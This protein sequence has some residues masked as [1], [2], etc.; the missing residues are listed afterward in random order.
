VIG[1]SR[2][3]RSGP[4]ATLWCRCVIAGGRRAPDLSA[5][6]K[7]P[8]SA[9]DDGRADTDVAQMDQIHSYMVSWSRIANVAR[10]QRSNTQHIELPT[11]R[12]E[13]PSLAMQGATAASPRR[14]R[15]M[16]LPR[17]VQ[18]Y[19]YVS[20]RPFAHGCA[21]PNLKVF[22]SSPMGLPTPY[23][24]ICVPHEVYPGQTHTRRVAA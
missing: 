20:G 12:Q 14:H 9:L 7:G 24:R 2:Q 15:N 21:I 3:P 11:L 19:V 18:I 16:V 23:H 22:S 5:I 4:Q 1:R 8:H 10:W 13:V 6:P 17:G